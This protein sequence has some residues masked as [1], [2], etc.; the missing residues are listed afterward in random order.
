MLRK[1]SRPTEQVPDNV[2]E[3]MIQE[4]KQVCQDDCHYFI[5]TYVRIEDRD[6]AGNQIDDPDSEADGIVIPFAMWA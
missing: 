2:I 1:E 6:E 3:D 5:K 4:E